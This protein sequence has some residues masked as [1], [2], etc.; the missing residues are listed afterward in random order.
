MKN[1]YFLLFGAIS[2]AVCLN[3]SAAEPLNAPKTTS[4]PELLNAAMECRPSLLSL[5]CCNASV[6]THL[7]WLLPQTCIA[8]DDRDFNMA[9]TQVKGNRRAMADKMNGPK[10]TLF[11]RDYDTQKKLF[12]LPNLIAPYN[13]PLSYNLSMDGKRIAVIHALEKTLSTEVAIFDVDTAQLLGTIKSLSKDPLKIDLNYDGTLAVIYNN[14][15]RSISLYD[16]VNGSYIHKLEAPVQAKRAGI[17]ETRLSY[18][19][20]KIGLYSDKCSKKMQ[21]AWSLEGIL[22][23][24]KSLNNLTLRQQLFLFFVHRHSSHTPANIPTNTHAY[25]TFE[26]L[27]PCL[28]ELLVKQQM[29]QIVEP[30]FIEKANGRSH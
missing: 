3:M 14:A 6:Y 2:L 8:A 25:K 24:K 17:M 22:N 10:Y 26:S 19:G 12:T 15:C 16:V 20:M 29:V 1:L 21:Y 11:V 7:T 27:A 5:G 30:V 13:L 18:D 9:P 23:L 4:D 28:K